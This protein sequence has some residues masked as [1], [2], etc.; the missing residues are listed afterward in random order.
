MVSLSSCGVGEFDL[1]D[2]FIQV[3]V[4]LVDVA[5][6]LGGVPYVVSGDDRGHIDHGDFRRDFVRPPNL[7]D[8]CQGLAEQRG[9]PSAD[10]VRARHGHTRFARQ[11][12]LD[13]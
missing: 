6:G 10:V 8:L 11:R 7:P 4:L 1:D 12:D 5:D 2:F 9:K 3:R 13:T